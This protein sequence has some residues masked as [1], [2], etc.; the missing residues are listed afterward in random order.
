M[1]G[2]KRDD[3]KKKQRKGGKA[4]DRLHQFE[5]ERGLDETDVDAPRPD[6]PLPKNHD[7]EEGPEDKP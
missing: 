4:L 5:Q 7:H 1:K 6:E 3:N 2:P